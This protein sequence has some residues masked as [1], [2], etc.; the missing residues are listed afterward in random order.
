MEENITGTIILAGLSILIT[1]QRSALI[2]NIFALF[3]FHQLRLASLLSSRTL[4]S[5]TLHHLH[6]LSIHQKS[7]LI[8]RHLLSTLSHVTATRMPP[9]N[10]TILNDHDRVNVDDFTHLLMLAVL[11]RLWNSDREIFSSLSMSASSKSGF[12]DPFSTDVAKITRKRS[13]PNKH[14]H[15][16][17]KSVQRA[18]DLIAERSNSQLESTNGQLKVKLGQL[19]SDIDKRTKNEAKLDKTEHGFGKSAKN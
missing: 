18:G 7:F 8:A 10:V 13:K 16:K 14:E 4:F 15:G 17:G 2:N 19:V 11:N 12:I 3:H 6:S 9:N 1:L 5:L